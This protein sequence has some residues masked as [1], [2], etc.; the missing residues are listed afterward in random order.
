[1]EIILLPFRNAYIFHENRNKKP[2]YPIKFSHPLK[3]YTEINKPENITI[4]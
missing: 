4:I 3:K 2:K 1:M